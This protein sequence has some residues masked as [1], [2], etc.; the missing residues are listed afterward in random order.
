MKYKVGDKVRIV[1]QRTGTWWN[2]KM[3]RWFGKVM[4]IDRVER[5]HYCMKEDRNEGPRMAI[6]G[7][8]WYDDMIAGP[9]YP[10][11]VITTDGTTTTATLREGKQVLRTA[12]AVC[13]PDDTYDHAADAKLALERLMEDK[14]EAPTHFTG[15]AM[16]IEKPQKGMD[17]ALTVG[18]LYTFDDG[19]FH[20][21]EGR[22]TL[23]FP[24]DLDTMSACGCR[25]FVPLVER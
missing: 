16:C 22:W 14:P 11:I 2:P 23:M 6:G 20:D 21:D 5:N 12:K 24:S 13:A 3:D 4:T 18:R 25:V 9:A 19:V 7:W 8:W 17:A 10:A 15:Q 1:S